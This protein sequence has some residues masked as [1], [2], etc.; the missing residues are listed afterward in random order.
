[1]SLQEALGV[2]ESLAWRRPVVATP[3]WFADLFRREYPV[4]VRIAAAVL[5]DG[6]RAEDVA[7]EAFTALLYSRQPPAEALAPPWLKATVVHRALN[8]LRDE[9]RRGRREVRAYRADP[10]PPEAAEPPAILERRDQ[11]RRV[12]AALA[13]LPRRD[14]AI[15]ALRHGGL[16]Y[17]EIAT[18]LHL[19]TAQIGTCLRRAEARLRKELSHAPSL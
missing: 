1:M 17:V 5:K 15:L 7:Q 6:G 8:V 12:R 16:H 19:P 11:V 14:A 9:E 4:L 2:G 13:R 3:P 18:A 10:A